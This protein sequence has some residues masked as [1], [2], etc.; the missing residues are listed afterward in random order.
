MCRKD[1]E[2]RRKDNRVC[3]KKMTKCVERMTY[4]ITQKMIFG[5]KSLKG[6]KKCSLK[7]R[8]L[9]LR[10]KQFAKCF[11][12]EKTNNLRWTGHLLWTY[13]LKILGVRLLR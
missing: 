7:F 5:H 4:C 8:V 3:R 12:F 2:M 6:V 9:A 1:D 10:A 13:I 11:F